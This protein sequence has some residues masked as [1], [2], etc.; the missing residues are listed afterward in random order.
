M[1]LET[2]I[3]KILLAAF[4][5]VALMSV[6]IFVHWWFNHEELVIGRK[7][8]KNRLGPGERQVLRGLALPTW[9]E[10]KQ[11]RAKKE[12][13]AAASQANP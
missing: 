3:E 11:N 9:Y 8:R 6:A 12:K 7:N 10:E 2:T 1:V 4:L 13:E 5:Y